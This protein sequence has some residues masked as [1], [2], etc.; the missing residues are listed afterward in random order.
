MSIQSD[1]DA[2]LLARAVLRL[3]RRLRA[4]RPDPSVTLAALALLSTLHRL[5]PMT[6]AR[7][8]EAERLQP[9]SLSRLLPKLEQ[10][11]L[12]LRDPGPLDRRTLVLSITPQGRKALSGDI[13]A[14]RA[15]L[16]RAMRDTLSPEERAQLMAAAELMLRL[17]DEGMEADASPV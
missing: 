5:G 14:R 6:A 7:L 16:E 12:I 15:W 3:G 17:A 1:S 11:G 2:A 10:A 9:Q 8:A 4:E 13:R